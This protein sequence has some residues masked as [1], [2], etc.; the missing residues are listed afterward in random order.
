MLA[1]LTRILGPANLGLAEDAVQEALL[2]A[3]ELW[4][5]QG[6]PENPQA[7]LMMVAKHRALDHLRREKLHEAKTEAIARS[8]ENTCAESTQ[9]PDDRLAMIFLCC[10]PALSAES[11]V[12]LTLKSVAGFGTAEIARAFF[13]TQATVAQ[14]LV[15]AKRQL[16]DQAIIFALPEGGELEVRLGSAMEVIYLIFNEGY[17]AHAGEKLM[18][19]D[20]CDEAI[21]LSSLLAANPATQSP[22][23]HALLALM[24]LLSGRQSSRQNRDGLPLLLEEQDRSQWDQ[25]RIARGFWHLE[26]SAAGDEESVYHVEA[27]IAAAHYALPVNW[28]YVVSLYDKLMHRKNSPIVLLHRS[29]A[30]SKRDGP[31]EGIRQLAALEG[32]ASMRGY[33]LL[34]AVLAELWLQAGDAKMAALYFGEALACE[35]NKPEQRRLELRLAACR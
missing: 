14:R 27:S 20:L 31:M 10:H 33:Y 21:F 26:Q 23:C 35:C 30:V 17:L 7:W 3:L 32:H 34:P 6:I 4:P 5:F 8:L 13:L 18:R 29:V 2:R 16:R 12:A 25:A 15:R 19:T 22:R 1:T 24:L 28:G 11:R 9:F